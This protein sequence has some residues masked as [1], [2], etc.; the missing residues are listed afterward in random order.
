MLCACACVCVSGVC[1]PTHQLA[2]LEKITFNDWIIF[3]V[4]S[5]VLEISLFLDISL[6]SRK[7]YSLCYRVFAHS[8]A[9]VLHFKSIMS[10]FLHI[11][12]AEL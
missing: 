11:T 1:V 4:L 2:L 5:F 3:L 12:F 8:A 6:S 7:F 9:A 10:L